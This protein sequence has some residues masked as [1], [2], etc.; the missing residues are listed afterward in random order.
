MASQQAGNRG[1]NNSA[2][3]S[4]NQ[5]QDQ[6]QWRIRQLEAEVATLRAATLTGG[7]RAPD[8]GSQ[9]QFARSMDSARQDSG[10]RI[11]SAR[12]DSGR[13]IMGSTPSSE[14]MVLR[15]SDGRPRVND[16]N[17]SAREQRAVQAYEADVRSVRDL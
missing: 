15:S 16:G 1:G 14:R 7:F 4:D 6:A 3:G 8:A 9:T 5:A 13:K 17:M 11:D 12:Q 2:R 10:R